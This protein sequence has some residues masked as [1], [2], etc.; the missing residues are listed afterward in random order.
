VGLEQ[1]PGEGQPLE[2]TLGRVVE[3]TCG[4]AE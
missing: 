2:G 1:P 4:V 3:I